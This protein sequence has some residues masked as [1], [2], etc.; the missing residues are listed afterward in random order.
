MS[1]LVQ[2]DQTNGTA[3]GTTTPGVASLPHGSV[4]AAGLDPVANGMRPGENSMEVWVRFNVTSLGGAG[5]VKG[6]R[7][8]STTPRPTGFTWGF[9]GHVTQGTYDATKKT[10]YE[11]PGTGAAKTPNSLPTSQPAS[12]NLGIGGSLQGVLTVPGTTDFLVSQHRYRADALA[13][14]PAGILTFEYDVTA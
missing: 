14:F 12:P 8:Y 4:D 10:V 5:S 6:F 2:I 11:T 13:G 7:L 1:A 3:P 9:N